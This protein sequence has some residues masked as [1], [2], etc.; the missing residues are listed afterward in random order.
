MQPPRVTVRN[1]S[2][3]KAAE[4]TIREKAAKLELFCD[5]ITSCRVVVEAPHRRHHQGVLYNV[6]IDMAVPGGELV[7]TRESHEDVYVAIRDAFDAAR[8]QLQYYAGR[9]RSDVKIHEAPHEARVSKLFPGEGF[10]FLETPDGREIYFHRNSVLNGSFDRLK[11]GTKVRF[12]EERGE[13][14]PQAST[15]VILGKHSELFMEP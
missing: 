12:S 1:V 11:V 14:G 5:R 4:A 13:Q 6:R 3:S 9:Q 10:G 8:R 15:V 7:V 2:L